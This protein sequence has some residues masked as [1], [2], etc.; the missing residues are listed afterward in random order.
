MEKEGEAIVRVM[1]AGGCVTCGA[2][3]KR[4]CRCGMSDRDEG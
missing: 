3:D 4:D 2:F 1:C